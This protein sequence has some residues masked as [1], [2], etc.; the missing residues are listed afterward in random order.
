MRKNL[1]LFKFFFILFSLLLA[2]CSHSKIDRK[3]TLIVGSSTAPILLD[4]RMAVDAEGQKIGALLYD[5]LVTLNEKQEPAP[6]LA[7]E[8]RKKGPLSYLFYLRKGVTLSNG[9][10][11]TAKDVACTFETIQNPSNQSPLRSEFEKV[12][13]EIVEDHTIVLHLKEP[14]A[15][16]FVMLKKGIV[17]CDG[18]SGTGP[19][20]LVSFI[21]GKKVVLKANADYFLGAPKIPNLIF[22][23]IKDDMTRVLK[24][25]RGEV[26]LVQNGIPALLIERVLQNKKIRME[27]EIG[28]TFSYMGLNLKDPIL[29]NKAVR[30]AMAYALDREAVIKHLWK[31]RAQKANSLLVPNHWAFEEKVPAYDHNLEKAKKLLDEA[32][33]PNPDGEGPSPRFSLVY[34]TST[35]KERVEIAK[36][37]AHQL[38]QVGIQVTMQP[39]EWGTFFRDIKSGNYQIYTLSWVGVSE[40]DLYYNILHSKQFPPDGANR[41]F[42]INP[43]AD[44]LT[45][46]GRRLLEFK[47]RRPIYSQIQKLVNEELPFIPLWYENN[48][49]LYWDDLKGVRLSADP[50]LKNFVHIYR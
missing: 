50:N 25:I 43:Q 29:K 19:Y 37:L 49:V 38:K 47:E 18:K 24:L 2:G 9:Q 26:D 36:L 45:E 11:F 22:E 27:Q 32:G 28:T 23:V 4:P 3:T 39:F 13:I 34:K 48:I 10:E 15:P 14:Y 1:I 31:G 33:F 17:G 6:L 21:E 5:G 30:Q 7:V 41:N 40:P 42:F 16:F 35:L 20:T 44:Q 8:W 46:K 12:T